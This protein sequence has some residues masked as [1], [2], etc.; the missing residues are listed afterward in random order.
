[1]LVCWSGVP[2]FCF[3]LMVSLKQRKKYAGDALRFWLWWKWKSWWWWDKCNCEYTQSK[4]AVSWGLGVEFLWCKV[5]SAIFE[6]V[7]QLSQCLEGV[8]SHTHEHR[9]T[10]KMNDF[11]PWLKLWAQTAVSCYWNQYFIAI[12]FRVHILKLSSKYYWNKSASSST[13][14][15]FSLRPALYIF[16]YPGV[17]C[18][19][20]HFQVWAKSLLLDL[21]FQTM[22]LCRKLSTHV[23]AHVSNLELYQ[24]K[25]STFVLN[26]FFLS[27]KHCVWFS[28]TSVSY[29]FFILNKSKMLANKRFL[30]VWQQF[31]RPSAKLCF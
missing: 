10:Q 19:R 23:Q 6:D 28:V 16:F 20:H 8:V 21:I 9:H 27:S 13:S 5:Q 7:L 2:D 4:P 30:R 18:W 24:L 17:L 26:M 25:R 12:F 29:L 1:M 11:C 3:V 22:F 14:C 15:S 31:H